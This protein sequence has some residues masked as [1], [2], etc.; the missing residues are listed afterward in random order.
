MSQNVSKTACKWQPMPSKVLPSVLCLPKECGQGL[1]KTPTV[2][3]SEV[4]SVFNY[5]TWVAQ[6]IV[7]VNPLNPSPWRTYPRSKRECS[8][9][10]H[11]YNF[12]CVTS[13]LAMQALDTAWLRLPC[14]LGG[15]LGQAAASTSAAT[16]ASPRKCAKSSNL[17][18]RIPGAASSHTPCSHRSFT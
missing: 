1:A 11:E 5:Y 13:L 16:G 8:S 3:V 15:P 10:F 17:R 12:D 6:M 7:L 18:G 4:V 14:C 9:F 2:G